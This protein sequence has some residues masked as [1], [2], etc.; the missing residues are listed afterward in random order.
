MLNPGAIQ[1]DPPSLSTL[2]NLYMQAERSSDRAN[3]GLGLG[4]ALVKSMIGL[5]GGT[6]SAASDG[7]NMGSSFV[8]TLPS[9]P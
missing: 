9:V 4:L 8:I 3:G 6:V 7:K 1:I 5:H 2:L